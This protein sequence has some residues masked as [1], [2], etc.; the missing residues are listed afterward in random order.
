MDIVLA[1]SLGVGV[2]LFLSSII[3]YW[4]NRFYNK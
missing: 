1:F 4:F 3:D 2:G